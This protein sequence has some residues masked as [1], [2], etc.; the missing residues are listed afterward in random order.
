MSHND[1]TTWPLRVRMSGLPVVLCG[2]NTVY[3]RVDTRS[4]DD[5]PVY[6]L[7]PYTLWGVFPIIG[8]RLMR[9]RG[10]WGLHRDCDLLS[11]DPLVCK[12][13]HGDAT[14]IGL[15]SDGARVT[16]ADSEDAGVLCAVRVRGWH[17]C[18]LA[19]L[20]AVYLF[21]RK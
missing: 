15:W 13:R 14:P 18:T 20:V 21:L 4:S 10:Q 8:V 11:T 3:H 9:I 12:Q 16:D 19:I 1:N 7:Q 6:R 2:W 5:V 17:L